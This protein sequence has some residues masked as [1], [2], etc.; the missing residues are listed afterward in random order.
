[1]TLSSFVR[2]VINKAFDKS[3]FIASCLRAALPALLVAYH[4]SHC[5]RELLQRFFPKLMRFLSKSNRPH[6]IA[7]FWAM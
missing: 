2:R 6:D 4:R 7:R 1:M 5:S 3:G